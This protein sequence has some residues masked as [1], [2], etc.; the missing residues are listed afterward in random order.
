MPSDLP[1]ALLRY[2][3]V[4]ATGVVWNIPST[5]PDGNEV[6]RVCGEWAM[7]RGHSN[8]YMLAQGAWDDE[9]PDDLRTTEDEE[10]VVT[11]PLCYPCAFD[12]ER[13]AEHIPGLQLMVL[14]FPFNVD[15]IHI[16]D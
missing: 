9:H 2:A 7:G 11:V 16:E 3:T 8:R 13:S 15:N 10:G 4:T 12:Y 5:T 14:G 6:C 1:A